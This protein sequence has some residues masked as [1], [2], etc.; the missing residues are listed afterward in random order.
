MR[1]RARPGSRFSMAGSPPGKP[2]RRLHTRSDTI[3][4]LI[5]FR[6]RSYCFVCDVLA[7]ECSRWQDPV[8]HQASEHS[9]DSTTLS[10]A[11]TSH[12]LASDKAESW[13]RI[14][15]AGKHDWLRESPLY[16]HLG[17]QCY[18]A[19]A[20]YVVTAFS[21]FESFSVS[22]KSSL[23]RVDDSRPRAQAAKRQ[24]SRATLR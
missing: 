4:H 24:R 8:E 22:S 10:I 1:V 19:S 13:L 7:S 21:A 16:A 20:D 6:C 18:G 17:A 12:C 2:A 23:P 9:T 5:G 14:R 15:K 3:L 11:N